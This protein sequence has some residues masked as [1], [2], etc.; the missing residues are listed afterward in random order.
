MI[1]CIYVQ[2]WQDRRGDWQDLIVDPVS[3][4]SCLSLGA[5]HRVLV[6]LW[7]CWHLYAPQHPINTNRKIIS[8]LSEMGPGHATR[9]RVIFTWRK[10]WVEDRLV[11][12]YFGHILSDHSSSYLAWHGGGYLLP[13]PAHP[14]CHG[15]VLLTCWHSSASEVPLLPGAVT[16]AGSEMPSDVSPLWQPHSQ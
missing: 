15:P 9:T 6:S 14:G 7:C 12:V 16:N 11:C 4:Q 8:G 10:F 2:S 3:G 13:N 5:A 1:C